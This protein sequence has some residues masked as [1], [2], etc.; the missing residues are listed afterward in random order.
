MLIA[1][2]LNSNF[3][4]ADDFEDCYRPDS[5]KIVNECMDHAVANAPYIGPLLNTLETDRSLL[6]VNYAGNKLA[7]FGSDSQFTLTHDSSESDPL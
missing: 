4:C 1:L 5:Q 3:A 2:L 7:N 6:V